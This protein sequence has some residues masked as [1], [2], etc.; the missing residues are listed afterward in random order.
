[1]VCG[2]VIKS[3]NCR[4]IAFFYPSFFCL[5][6][7]K[8]EYFMQKFPK[9]SCIEAAQKRPE[10]SS[11]STTFSAAVPQY[12]MDLDE[13]KALAMGV[14]L[15]ELYTTLQGTFG[16]LYVNDF[17]YSG[18]SF[19]VMMQADGQYRARP[20]Q[21]SGVYVRSNSGAMVPLSTL[22]S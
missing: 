10:L 11:V 6:N 14:S 18:R 2:V 15:S 20:E 8:V 17:T 4:T 19:T 21:I 12:K 5:C 16:T 13:T 1:M 3:A 9:S 22:A 7:F